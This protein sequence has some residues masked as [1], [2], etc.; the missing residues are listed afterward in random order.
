MTTR[1]IP[2]EVQERC[3]SLLI[4]IAIVLLGTGLALALTPAIPVLRLFFSTVPFSGSCS[5]CA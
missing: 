5:E 1:R 4:S 3:K 2:E